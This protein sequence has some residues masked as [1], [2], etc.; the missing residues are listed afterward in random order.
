MGNE[1]HQKGAKMKYQQGYVRETGVDWEANPKPLTA[2]QVTAYLVSKGES[3]YYAEGIMRMAQACHLH[4][5]ENGVVMTPF[6]RLR[7]AP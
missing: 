7:V 2:K 4:G 3:E 5:N 6:L 1:P